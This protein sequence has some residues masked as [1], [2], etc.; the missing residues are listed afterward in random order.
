MRHPRRSFATAIAGLVAGALL[1]CAAHRRAPAPP[2]TTSPDQLIS[3]DSAQPVEQLVLEIE[4]HNWSDIVVFVVH[5]GLTSRLTQVTAGRSVSVP[6]LPRHVGAMGTLR[7]AVHPIGGSSDYTSESVSLRTGST[8][9]LTVE[10][11][12]GRS[13]VAVW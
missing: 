4:N 10:S 6:L 1:G 13:S 12:V 9:R 11:S 7:L 5:D 8:I 3:A 2:P